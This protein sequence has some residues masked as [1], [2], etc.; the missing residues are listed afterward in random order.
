MNSLLTVSTLPPY[1][2]NN[3]NTSTTPQAQA[4]PN[5]QAQ[6]QA[7]AQSTSTDTGTNANTLYY[8]FSSSA[9]AVPAGQRNP[10]EPRMLKTPSF[11]LTA[12]IET[13]RANTNQDE[14]ILARWNELAA[15]EKA[16][17]EQER[18][19]KEKEKEKGAAQTQADAKEKEAQTQTQTQTVKKP[20]LF[21]WTFEEE[22]AQLFRFVG[23]PARDNC[24][25]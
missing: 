4:Q 5:A 9:P 25:K 3:T 20:Q 18:A 13:S 23:H 14:V 24:Y 1:R 8:Q 2:I 17:I 7:Q 12:F 15:K 10:N 22:R 11:S 21:N 19:E 6:T 16:K